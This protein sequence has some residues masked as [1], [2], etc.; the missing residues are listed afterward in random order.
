[1]KIIF[2]TDTKWTKRHAQDN[3]VENISSAFEYEIW[4]ASYWI[5]HEIPE[6]VNEFEK[7]FITTAEEFDKMLYLKTKSEN[8]VFISCICQ[9]RYNIIFSY[10]KKYNVDLIWINKEGWNLYW[11]AQ[12]FRYY[13]NECT[14]IDRFRMWIYYND[15][16]RYILCRLYHKWKPY[17][18][19]LT[20]KNYWKEI[21]RRHIPIHHMKYDEYLNTPNQK[22]INGEY[23]VFIDTALVTHK[24]YDGLVTNREKEEYFTD[25]NRYLD[26]FEKK[27]NIKVV[28]AGYPK[29]TNNEKDFGNR[30]VIYYKTP[31]LIKNSVVVITHYT[32]SIITAVFFNKP[33]V[34]LTWDKLN[35]N[36][37]W[38]NVKVNIK[39]YSN[40]LGQVC[41][42]ISKPTNISNWNTDV[43][44]Y[45]SFINNH[46][47]CEDKK[48]LSNKQLILE[49]LY[50]YEKEK[51][52]N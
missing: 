8:I 40:I 21:G 35:E 22:I 23:A 17:D 28:V 24:M 41:D 12:A 15:I 5:E 16:S 9:S 6:K 4:D 3:Q 33:I 44:S 37:I 51:F 46:L 13:G 26:E 20:P 10:L 27:H 48:E 34:F 31:Q 43:S 19:N 50:N 52:L 30:E 2:F 49:F 32:T 1:M 7:V 25:L 45:N 18:Y 47:I 36:R 14:F 11:T 42:N 39:L 29:I 38:T